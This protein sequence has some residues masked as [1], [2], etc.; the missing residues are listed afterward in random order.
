MSFNE[1]KSVIFKYVIAF[2]RYLPPY[3]LFM[4]LTTIKKYKEEVEDHTGNEEKRKKTGFFVS[5]LSFLAI[6]VFFISI[7]ESQN[8]RR[9]PLNSNI[10]NITLEVIRYIVINYYLFCFIYI[11]H[12]TIS[13]Y[14]N[15]CSY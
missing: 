13:I 5:Q 4:P 7:T 8:L 6:S 11:Q 1:K 2:T 14:D 3:T 15:K 9:D 12:V 10:L